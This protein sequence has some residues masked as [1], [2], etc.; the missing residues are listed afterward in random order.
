MI[1]E[2][3]LTLLPAQQDLS[4]VFWK[5]IQGR[6]IFLKLH[7]RACLFVRTFSAVKN[8]QKFDRVFLEE[9]ATK[10]KHKIVLIIKKQDVLFWK[11]LKQS[12]ADQKK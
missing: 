5:C 7:S 1:F 12:Q 3:T 8:L 2:L 4:L 9:E 6:K 10:T 11:K